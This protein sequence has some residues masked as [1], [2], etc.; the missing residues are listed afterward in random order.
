MPRQ[1]TESEL[2]VSPCVASDYGRFAVTCRRN[3]FPAF[4]RPERAPMSVDKCGQ[5]Q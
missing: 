1:C 2:D 4:R 3:R 5:L